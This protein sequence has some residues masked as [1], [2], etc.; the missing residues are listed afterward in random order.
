MLC[1]RPPPPQGSLR[2]S[3]LSQKLWEVG[4]GMWRGTRVRRSHRET[5]CLRLSEGG[6]CCPTVSKAQGKRQEVRHGKGCAPL[7]WA[8]RNASQC[9]A[10]LADG[11]PAVLAWRTL[12]LGFQFGEGAVGRTP[13]LELCHS[14]CT[15]ASRTALHVTVPEPALH[16]LHQS[17]LS[18]KSVTPQLPPSLTF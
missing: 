2:I 10:V 9:G 16:S 17:S 11:A 3:S 7:G 15:W 6:P 5:H 1:P 14:L 18:F 4:P 8:C 13:P 12:C